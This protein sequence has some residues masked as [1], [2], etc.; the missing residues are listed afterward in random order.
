MRTPPLTALGSHERAA[1]PLRACGDTHIKQS[2][3]GRTLA[4]RGIT[5]MLPSMAFTSHEA[6]APPLKAGVSSHLECLK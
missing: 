1:P 4:G 2:V 6:A 5:R 3:P